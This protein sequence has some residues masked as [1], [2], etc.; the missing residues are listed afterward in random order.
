MFFSIMAARTRE[1]NHLIVGAI[2]TAIVLLITL[3]NWKDALYMLQNRDIFSLLFFGSFVIIPIIFL[4]KS[5]QSI[6]NQSFDGSTAG[7][8]VTEEYLDEVINAPDEDID[9]DKDYDLR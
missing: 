1:Q 2:A 8:P 5:Q 6:K 7:G 9:F 3:F 4:I